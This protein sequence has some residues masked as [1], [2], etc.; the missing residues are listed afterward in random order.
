[1]N[2][3]MLYDCKIIELCTYGICLYVA[4][5]QMVPRQPQTYL[6]HQQYPMQS[7]QGGD[8]DEFGMFQSIRTQPVAATV[9]VTSSYQQTPY[10]ALQVNSQPFASFPQPATTSS[11]STSVIGQHVTASAPTDEEFGIFQSTNITN[12]GQQATPSSGGHSQGNQ[13]SFGDF[14]SGTDVT[15]TTEQQ[16]VYSSTT[17]MPSPYWQC[18][19]DQLPKLYQDVFTTCVMTDQFLDTQRLFPIL[20]SS[21]LQRS[22]LRD[23]WS[24]VNQVQP[25]RLT[26]EELWQALGLVALAQVKHTLLIV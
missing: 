3:Y 8:G 9:V 21:G 6:Q 14:Q 15:S 23:I 18:S 12:I 10:N 22:L 25:G 17:P 20:T 16:A 7:G 1:M 4:V 24:T 19:T 11:Q 13:D 26:K 2:T 5:N